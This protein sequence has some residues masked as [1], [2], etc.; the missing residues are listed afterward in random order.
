MP[1]FTIIYETSTNLGLVVEAEDVESAIDEADC[2]GVQG[3]CHQCT[4]SW[5]RKGP[6]RWW[7]E[8]GDETAVVSVLDWKRRV[9]Q[10]LMVLL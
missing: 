10:L 9:C 3:L 2:E 4:G 1:E 5:G 7:R 6:G 8:E